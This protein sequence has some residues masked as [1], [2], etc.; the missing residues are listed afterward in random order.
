MGRHV[1]IGQNVTI[2][3]VCKIGD[4]SVIGFGSVVTKSCKSGSVMAG[5]PAQVVKEDI[6]W[7][8]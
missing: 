3:K 6:T 7:D 5:C 8:Y 4:D 1:W 2:L